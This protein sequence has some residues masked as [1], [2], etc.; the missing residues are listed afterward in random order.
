LCTGLPQAALALAT[1]FFICW[2]CG[3]FD[4]INEEGHPG[5]VRPDPCSH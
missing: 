4:S 3:A 1:G 2:T 5:I